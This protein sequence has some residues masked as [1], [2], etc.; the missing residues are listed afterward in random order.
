MP[1]DNEVK[2]LAF[3]AIGLMI[4]FVFLCGQI[5]LRS[6]KQRND[7]STPVTEEGLKQ[8]DDLLPVYAAVLAW[9]DPGA[10]ERWHNK[11]K[12]DVREKMPLLARALDRMVEN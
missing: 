4:L 9:T 3:I 8:F 1:T 7:E 6:R 12:N 11:M 2:I 10:N 5:I